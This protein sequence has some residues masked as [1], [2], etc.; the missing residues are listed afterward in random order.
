MDFIIWFREKYKFQELKTSEN[1]TLMKM[2]NRGIKTGGCL[3]QSD[4]RQGC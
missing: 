4:S 2:N 3:M 1:W